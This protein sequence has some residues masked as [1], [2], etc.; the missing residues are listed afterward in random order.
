M[1]T[2]SVTILSEPSNA[3]SSGHGFGPWQRKVLEPRGRL[4][5]GT[6]KRRVS[7]VPSSWPHGW[8]SA[9]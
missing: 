4:H 6:D 5:G 7:N 3:K 1:G 8:A 9:G 2:V